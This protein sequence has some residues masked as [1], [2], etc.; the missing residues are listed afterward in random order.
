MAQNT[1]ISVPADT[2]T[3]LTDADATNVTFTVLDGVAYI[4]ATVDA[5]AP[6]TMAGSV[7]YTPAM[8]GERNVPILELFPGIAGVRL[9][10]FAHAP[11][12]ITVSHA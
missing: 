12:N 3:Q 9:W 11:V 6:T 2:W 5:T 8:P 4:K 1:T 10:A 7:K